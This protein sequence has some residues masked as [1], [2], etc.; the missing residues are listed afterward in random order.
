VRFTLIK[1]LKQDN[2][3]KPILSGL[4]LFIIIYIISDVMVKQSS[5]GIFAHEVQLTLFGNADEFLEPISKSSFL[6]FI[7]MEIFFLM[8]ILLTLSAVFARLSNKQPYSI[9]IINIAMISALTSLITL[10]LTYFVNDSFINIYV[11]SFFTWHI[12][13][14]YMALYSLWKL[15]YA[16]SV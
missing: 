8:M 13:T 10:G 15:H 12:V 7:H 11:G 3:M 16:K 9:L 1:D 5:F 4:L 14:S 6:E 2:A